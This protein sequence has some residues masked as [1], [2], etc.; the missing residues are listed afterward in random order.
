MLRLIIK[1]QEFFNEET[2]EFVEEDGVVLELEHSLVSLSKWESK[3][4][5]PFLSKDSKSQEELLDYIKFMVVTDNHPEDLRTALSVE[6]F[7]SIQSY[8][9][10]PQSATTFGKLPQQKGRSEIITSELIYYWLVVFN[11]PFEVEC[12]HLN[13]LLALVRICNLKNQKPQKVKKGE[14]ARQYRELN[15]Q[16]RKQYGTT[17]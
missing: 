6:H 4:Q 2:S 9:D 11:I 17:G 7:A 5:K 8:I 1:G 14:A 16:R 3:F 10:S 13:R 12:W 15:E